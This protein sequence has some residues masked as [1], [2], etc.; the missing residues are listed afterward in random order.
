MRYEKRYMMMRCREFME[1]LRE[2]LKDTYEFGESPF[3]AT[4]CYLVP[5]G[6][7]DQNTYY[8]KPQ[9]SF[10][11]SDH[12][13]WYANLKKC[14]EPRYVQCYNADAL[15]PN[16]REGSGATKPIYICCVGYFTGTAFHCVFGEKFDRKT[17]TY[18]WVETTP[19]EVVERLFGK[20]A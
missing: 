1:G 5:N 9:K 3:A 11:C 17:K 13:S 4:S 14:S 16:R 2:L 19:Q 10:R 6:T 7:A 15:W 20:A 8:S 12:W 18:S